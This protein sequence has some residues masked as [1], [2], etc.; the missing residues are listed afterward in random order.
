MID[1]G[2]QA[3]KRKRVAKTIEGLTVALER[4]DG[5]EDMV[6][7]KGWQELEHVLLSQA[8]TA[9]RKMLE[10]SDD[11]VRNAHYIE[12]LTVYRQVLIDIVTAPSRVIGKKQEIL[13][14]L[15][16]YEEAAITNGP[17]NADN[18]Q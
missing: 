17:Q 5:Y 12:K 6:I 8:A 11:A 15:K 16:H 18:R 2:L 9:L 3:L 7:T 4:I 13:D 14:K 1:W 10:V